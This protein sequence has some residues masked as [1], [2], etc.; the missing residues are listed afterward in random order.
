MISVLISSESRYKISRDRIRQAV[1]ILLGQAGLNDV[2]VSV[3]VV[4]K[5]K[6]RGLNRKYRQLD[7]PTDVLSFP[8]DGSRGPDG[9]LRLG[10][11]VISYPEVIGQA[12]TENKLV[13]QKLNELVE[14]GLRHL[15][16]EHHD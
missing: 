13:D 4:G 9:I 12:I 1:E 15:L 16:G 6:I 14:H 3:V 2:E 8:Q 7:E 5:R 10:D 11:I